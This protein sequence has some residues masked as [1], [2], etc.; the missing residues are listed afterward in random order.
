MTGVEVLSVNGDAVVEKGAVQCVGEQTG[1]EVRP[2]LSE[3]IA[4]EDRVTSR[5]VRQS[6][7]VMSMG[8]SGVRFPTFNPTSST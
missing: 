3:S 8:C 5:R 4:F 2:E 6:I 7:P 1:R